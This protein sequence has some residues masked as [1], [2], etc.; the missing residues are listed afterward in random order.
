MARKAG[1][2][3]A[4]LK[5]WLKIGKNRYGMQ[6]AYLPLKH[7]KVETRFEAMEDGRAWGAP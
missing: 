7:I 3:V 5:S 6:G 2:R 4:Q 1:T